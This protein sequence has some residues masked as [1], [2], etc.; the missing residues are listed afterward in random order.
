MRQ[1]NRILLLFFVLSLAFQSFAQDKVWALVLEKDSRRQ[2]WKTRIDFPGSEIR[3]AWNEGYRISS[4]TYGDGLWAI[5]YSKIS[6]FTAQRYYLGET[7]PKDDISRGWDDGYDITSVAYGDGQWAVIMSKF[8]EY[9]Q[10]R[11]RTR[12]EYPKDEI[13]EGYDDGYTISSLVYGNG[14][15]ALVMDKVPYHVPQKWYTRDHFPDDEISEGWDEGYDIQSLEFGDGKWALIMTKGKV[16]Y[17]QKWKKR[18]Y[19]P[20]DEISEAWDEGYA[21]RYISYGPEEALSE[22]DAAALLSEV[23]KPISTPKTTATPDIDEAAFLKELASRPSEV[24]IGGKVWMTK[25]L[26]VSYFRN[27]DPIPQVTS[28]EEWVKAGKEGRPAWC[29]YNNDSKNANTYGKLYNMYAVND[30]RGLAPFGWKIP[31]KLDFYELMGSLGSDAEE[32]ADQLKT[33]NGWAMNGAGNNSSGFFA[34]PSGIRSTDG[35]FMR[36][37]GYMALHGATVEVKESDG[38][39]KQ[40][41]TSIGIDTEYKVYGETS[42]IYGLSVRCIKE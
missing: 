39:T 15:W 20:K 19:F 16:N 34:V 1:T 2:K 23:G 14:V 33:E 26:D 29:Y 18:T 25:N 24:S 4:L 5:A 11:W 3:E 30:P 7:F 13:R 17:S 27:G 12:T 42:A 6:K 37:G 28:A 9:T 40:V 31:T 32:A 21:I 38:T 36:L 35:E 41:H 8:P 10:Q 22:S